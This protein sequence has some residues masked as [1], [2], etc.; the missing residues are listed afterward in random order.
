MDLKL[1]NQKTTFVFSAF[2]ADKTPLAAFEGGK[3]TYEVAMGIS[4]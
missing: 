3:S 1:E 4:L 2:G